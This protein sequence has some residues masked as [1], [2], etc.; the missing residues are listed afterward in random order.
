M[1]KFYQV[2]SFTNPDIIYTVRQLLDG[3]W[4]CSC[5]QGVFKGKCNHIRKVR[6]QKLKRSKK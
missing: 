3:S 5:P 2:K 4:H 6:H 1:T